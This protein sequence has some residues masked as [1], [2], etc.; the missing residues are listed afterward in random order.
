MQLSKNDTINLKG[1]AVIFLLIHHFLW[2]Y[3]NDS[4][5]FF[6]VIRYTKICVGIFIFLSGYG[7]VKSRKKNQISNWKFIIEKIKLLMIT[8]QKVFIIF[9]LLAMVFNLRT[10]QEAYNNKIFIKFIIEFLGIHEFFYGHGFNPTWGYMS[11]ILLLYIIFPFLH[12]WIKKY[13][14]YSIIYT[15]LGT[16]LL[17]QITKFIGYIQLNNLTSGFDYIFVFAV[18]IYLSTY[19]KKSGIPKHKI[20]LLLV[21]LIMSFFRIYIPLH[22]DKNVLFKVFGFFISS[23]IQIVEIIV[24]IYLYKLTK[25]NTQLER[26]LNFLGENSYII[27]LTHTLLIFA[28]DK[29]RFL[30]NVPFI[31]MMF[32]SILS[33]MLGWG[34]NELLKKVHKC[35]INC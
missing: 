13:K 4:L 25:L 9:I 34:I 12:A 22:S 23:R 17:S 19:E 27:F 24:I 30:S 10:M 35:R 15:Y 33:V 20:I 7:L 1:L 21:L 28:G 26:V 8:Y 32:Y 31:Y 16:L 11:L 2:N 3:M 5:G 18:G 14:V 6:Y 29:Y